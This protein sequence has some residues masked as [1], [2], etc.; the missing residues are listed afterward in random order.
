VLPVKPELHFFVQGA[1]A[2]PFAV[3]PTLAFRLSVRQSGNNVPIHTVVLRCQIRIEPGK[4]RYSDKE[5]ERLLDL[6]DRR[7]RWG[8]TL[9]SMLWTHTSVVLP[10]FTD[11]IAVDLPV[12]CTFDFNV[13]ATKYFRALEEG[14]VPLQLLFS[15]TIFH[16]AEQ[17]CLQ[18]AQI[19]WDKETTYRLPVN[20]WEQMMDHYYPNSAWLC[21]ERQSFDQLEAYKRHKGLPTFERTLESL[22][23]ATTDVDADAAPPG[24]PAMGVSP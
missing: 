4:R 6:F 7:E 5:Q 23:R 12:P 24:R 14:E 1:E 3:S 19:P 16:E 20:I 2:V 9:R 11:D 17:G 13:A 10:P 15:G 22:L 8:Q 21:L 18:V